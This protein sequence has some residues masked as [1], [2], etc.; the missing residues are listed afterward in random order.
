MSGY[1]WVWIEEYKCGCSEE[2]TA[3]PEVLGYCAVHGADRTRLTRLRKRVK[4]TAPGG[5][6]Q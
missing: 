5:S 3:K 1:Q 2:F 4:P 6:E